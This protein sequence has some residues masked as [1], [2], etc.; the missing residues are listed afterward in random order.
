MDNNYSR[1]VSRGRD[2]P[3]CTHHV[4]DQDQMV[5]KCYKLHGFSLG[6]K[7]THTKPSS[8][9]NVSFSSAPDSVNALVLSITYDQVQ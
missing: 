1:N 2:K 3:H 9:N 7:F 6:F 5:N 4:K 8:T